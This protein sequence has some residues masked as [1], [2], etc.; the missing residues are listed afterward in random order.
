MELSKFTS[1]CAK[2]AQFTDSCPE[3]RKIRALCAH[4]SRFCIPSGKIA[5][6]CSIHVMFNSLQ[7][8]HDSP[9]ERS[10]NLDRSF[11]IFI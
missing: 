2:S 10:H 6:I 7:I 3:L 8:L 4:Y 11:R 5:K 9:C 1:N